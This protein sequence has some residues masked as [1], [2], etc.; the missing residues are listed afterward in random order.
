MKYYVVF[1]KYSQRIINKIVTVL[2]RVY[3]IEQYILFFL[4]YNK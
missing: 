3:G 4:Y 2:N 1:D